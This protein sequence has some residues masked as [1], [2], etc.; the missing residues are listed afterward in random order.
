MSAIHDSTKILV[1]QAMALFEEAIRDGRAERAA[2]L[3]KSLLEV[4]E[5]T[6]NDNSKLLEKEKPV[7][8]ND[9]VTERLGI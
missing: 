7:F 8:G 3:R 4:F 9:H 5:N 1:R 6:I 2:E